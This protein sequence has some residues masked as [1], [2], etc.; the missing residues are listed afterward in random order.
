M[1]I[2]QLLAFNILITGN[3][4][5]PGMGEK[6]EMNSETAFYFQ[7][8][9]TYFPVSGATTQPPGGEDTCSM[10]LSQGIGQK[11]PG[12]CDSCQ[13][14]LVQN[15]VSERSNTVGY[16]LGD[17]ISVNAKMFPRLDSS[18]RAWTF[19]QLGLYNRAHVPSCLLGQKN[20][21]FIHSCTYSFNN[22]CRTQYFIG[23]SGT[24][25]MNNTHSRVARQE[26]RVYQNGMRSV[27]KNESG[28]RN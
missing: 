16:T 20:F 21:K 17:E 26:D 13:F 18:S 28:K 15:L 25:M 23:V 12:L 7:V 3:G 6:Q 27:K 8:S 4:L 22:V 1:N 24:R 2:T 9:K 11:S 14:H 19:K 10:F 5:M